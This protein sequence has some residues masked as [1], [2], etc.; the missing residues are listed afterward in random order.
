MR[1]ACRG[2]PSPCGAMVRRRR[3]NTATQSSA[4]TARW[5]RRRCSIFF[6]D[7]ALH[8]RGADVARRAGKI[9]LDAPVTAY[10]DDLELRHPI[11]LRQLASHSSGLPD[12]FSGFLAIH[13]RGSPMPSAAAALARYHTHKGRAPGGK[14]AY[15]NVNYAL[16]GAVI[17]RVSQQP[18]VEFV[19]T[20]LLGRWHS[21]ARF[22]HDDDMRSR[23]A[24]GYITRFHPMRL[25]ASRDDAARLEA[26]GTP[27]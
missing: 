9:E 13:F 10:L 5:S 23:A 20:E 22:E 3:W 6:G 8:R 4:R 24:V 21:Q 12:T 16:L 2:A 7:E 15:R 11:T 17:A 25:A 19:E 1:R 18:F 26:A 27:A 14:A